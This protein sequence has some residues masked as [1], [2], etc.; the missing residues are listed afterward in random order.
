MSAPPASRRN[1]AGFFS[2]AKSFSLPRGPR[3]DTEGL[4]GYY[5]DLRIKAETPEWPAPWY[6]EA[7]HRL[8]VDIAQ[9]GL[10]ALER[11]L[12]GEGE[13]WLAAAIAVGELLVREQRSDGPQQGA[14]VHDFRY[15]HSLPLPPGWPS[16]MAQGEAASLLVRLH[17]LTGE[18]SFADAARAAMLPLQVQSREGGAQ[19][20][21]GGAAFPEE[22]PTDPPSF[23]L[24]GAIF[25]LWGVRDTAVALGDPALMASFEAGVDT[26]AANI[27]RWDLGYWSRYDLFPRPV[28][29]PASSFY[30]ALH[31]SQLEAMLLVAPRPEL[32]ATRER[33]ETYAASRADRWR[34][35]AGKAL[36]RLVVPRNRLLAHRLPWTRRLGR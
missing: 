34:G 33:F 30:H 32:A 2:S 21:L 4:D 7:D 23:V 29:N 20:L 25:A 27:H 17:R 6:Q 10:G 36:Y 11:H 5:I 8:F 16:A 9:W 35:F 14:W 26:L 15:P 1:R 19:A 31:I 28:V 24:N 18:P 22:Y 3:I 12:A 13:R